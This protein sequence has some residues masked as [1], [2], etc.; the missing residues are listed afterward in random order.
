MRK[1]CLKCHSYVQYGNFVSKIQCS[2]IF[3]KHFVAKKR[4]DYCIQEYSF[5]KPLQVHKIL[6]VCITTATLFLPLQSIGNVDM[7]SKLRQ[8]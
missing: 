7:G 8:H 4:T 1:M 5:E 2:Y 3:E 6:F